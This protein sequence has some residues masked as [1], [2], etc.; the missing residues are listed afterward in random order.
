MQLIRQTAPIYYD[1]ILS[2]IEQTFGETE[3]EDELPQLDGSEK[4]EN[5]D[6]IYSA[7]EGG[8]LI[9]TIHA[10]IPKSYPELCG[11]SGMCISS[12]ARGKGIG[13]LMFSE[14]NKYIDEL[15]VKSVFLGTSNPIAAKMYGG[16]GFSYIPGSFV[17]ARFNDGTIV[18]YKNKMYGQMGKKVIIKENSAAMRIPIIPLVMFGCNQI[19]MDS[20]TRLYSSRV[21]TQHSCMGIHAKYERLKSDGGSFWGAFDER[22][23]LGAVLS[24]MPFENGIMAAFF[25]C[26]GFEK[27][28][29]NMIELCVSKYKNVEFKIAQIDKSKTEMIENLGYKCFSDKTEENL[30]FYTSFRIYK[31]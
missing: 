21:F 12:E 24:A 17:M 7:R 14:I 9:G 23:I 2:L 22:G 4:E 1:E 19:V 30:G 29:S 5:L 6:I 13:K 3:A 16:V 31:K 26:D 28:I 27:A 8:K 25:F 10:T 18:D 20:N 11:L 15:G